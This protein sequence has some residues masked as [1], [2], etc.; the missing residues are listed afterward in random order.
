MHRVRVRVPRR[1]GR[2]A[3]GHG[4][5][6]GALHTGGPRQAGELRAS[7]VLYV[8]VPPTVQI[9]DHVVVDDRV[10]HVAVVPPERVPRLFGAEAGGVDGPQQVENLMGEGG[11]VRDGAAVGWD[12]GAHP[13]VRKPVVREPGDLG[14][15]VGWFTPEIRSISRSN[16]AVAA[17]DTW[18]SMPG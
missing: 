15:T 10:V 5:G 7:D 12:D 8:V 18:S 2:L 13:G 11:V 14:G 9:S 3:G 4:L 6:A 17:M 1:Q 16:R